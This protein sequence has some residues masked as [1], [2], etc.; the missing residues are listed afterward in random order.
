MLLHL[1]SL[2]LQDEGG[3]LIGRNQ[4]GGAALSPPRFHLGRT[5]HGNLWRFA[6]DVAAET[7]IE[8]ARLAAAERSS[9][10]LVDGP[11]RIEPMRRCLEAAAPIEVAYHG[12][13]FRFPELGALPPSDGL[14]RVTPERAELLERHFSSYLPT[15]PH[16]APYV[17]AVEEGA[18]VTICHSARS[19]DVA[20]QAG[21]ETAPGW[22]RRGMAG[23]VVAGWAR[24]VADSGR[25]P[26]YSTWWE[27]AASRAVAGRLGLIPFG[28][29][30][31]FR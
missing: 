27:N 12:P 3:R 8:L 2:Y 20:A 17:V 30:L 9:R 5:A 1:D 26:L 13:A 6:A 16:E 28:A 14:I 25:I 19:S 4:P 29:D 24:D 15:F 7:V 10:P 22:R 21:V 31:H 18:A 23:P 11:E